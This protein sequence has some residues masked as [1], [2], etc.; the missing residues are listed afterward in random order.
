[1]YVEKKLLGGSRLTKVKEPPKK[2]HSFYQ[3][4]F[5]S[6]CLFGGVC[7][8]VCGGVGGRRQNNQPADCAPSFSL[9]VPTHSCQEYPLPKTKKI[10]FGFCSR[11]LN[12]LASPFHLDGNTIVLRTHTTHRT[13]SPSPSPS[14]SLPPSLCL[15]QFSARHDPIPQEGRKQWRAWY[16]AFTTCSKPK[17]TVPFCNN[18]PQT[19]GTTNQ[20]GGARGKFECRN[21]SNVKLTVAHTTST[22]PTYALNALPPSC[23]SVCTCRLVCI[24]GVAATPCDSDACRL[25]S[26]MQQHNCPAR[27]CGPCVWTVC[28]DRVCGLFGGGTAGSGFLYA[29][30]DDGITW[31][32]PVM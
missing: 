12:H 14:P 21:T 11:F 3:P 1:M 23:T 5:L 4:R 22:T 10:R 24:C 29:E 8:G 27:V 25:Q 9:P 15:S 13:T 17:D 6:P 2:H 32:K 20:K 30:S 19:C 26:V 31:T 7:G 18:A 16:S 28:V